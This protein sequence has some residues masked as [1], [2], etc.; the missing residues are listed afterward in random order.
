MKLGSWKSVIFLL[1]PFCVCARAASSEAIT[2]V[3]SSGTGPYQEALRGL[4]EELNEE[5][6]PIFLG[7][8][9]PQIPSSA[10]V[11]IAFGSKAALR[12]YPRG[13]VLVY[14]M[15]PGTIVQSKDSI[16][17]CMEPDHSVL[18]K[19]LKKIHPDLKR[20]GILW[21]STRFK[22]Y[23]GELRDAAKPFGMTI[24]DASIESGDHVPEELRRLHGRIDALWL[25]PD[26]L[27]VNAELLPVFV[28]FSRSNKVPLFVSTVG[29]LG[30]GATASVGP[31]F[32][33]MGRQVGI[34]A[35]K[36]LLNQRQEDKIYPTHI[37]IVVNK[38][39]AAQVG[40]QVPEDALRRSDGVAP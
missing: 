10:K 2:A 26:P 16:K 33:E 18:L 30:Q 25:I 3:F 6:R 9:E 34:A 14:A 29:L 22:A 4:K 5:V 13:I 1:A 37:E 17:I 28:Q 11:V 21:E 36:A 27:L 20:L 19:S 23:I 8:G 32:R 35:R 12:Q 15:A 24:E 39:V 38:D 7:Q 31:S 40:L